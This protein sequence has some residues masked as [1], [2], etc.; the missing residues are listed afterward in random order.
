MFIVARIEPAPGTGRGLF[1]S[2]A[3]SH[4]F[5]PVSALP[6]EP[7]PSYRRNFGVPC[8]CAGLKEIAMKKI[9]VAALIAGSFFSFE[10]RAQ[11]RAGDAA[12]GAVSGAVVLGPV[13]AVAGAV[14]GYTAGPS[15]ARSW[16]VGRSASRSRA[17]RAAQSSRGTQE[18]G[19]QEPGK[20]ELATRE[21]A[22]ATVSSPPSMKS[23]ET[24]PGKS[25][26]PPVQGF[27]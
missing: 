18:L 13:G 9:L 8:R 19:T 7:V 2:Q 12:L 4:P 5:R 15:I 26:A 23:P 6:Q 20:Q 24:L 10:A 1:E 22:T 27:D 17:Q 21:Q 25:V 16:G 3:S 14:I 11:N